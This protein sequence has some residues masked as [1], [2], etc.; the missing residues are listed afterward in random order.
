MWLSAPVGGF[1]GS[2]LV[3]VVQ[4]QKIWFFVYFAV[5]KNKTEI[6]HKVYKVFVNSVI[7]ITINNVMFV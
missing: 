6:Y 3:M 4:Q 7:N 5:P 1:D 2:E